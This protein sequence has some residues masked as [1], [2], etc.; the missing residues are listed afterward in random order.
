M[1]GW[2]RARPSSAPQVSELACDKAALRRLDIERG[3]PR[4]FH[5]CQ[6]FLHASISGM[7]GLKSNRPRAG[8]E[9]PGKE[10]MR[11]H[12][13]LRATNPHF[14]KIKCGCRDCQRAALATRQHGG[15]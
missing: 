4:I 9:I 11:M 7:K 2:A 15:I 14:M 3:H 5:N 6:Y 8:K 1:R 13:A 12:I 10:K